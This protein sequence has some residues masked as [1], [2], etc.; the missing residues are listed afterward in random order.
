MAP[1]IAHL[2]ANAEKCEKAVDSAIERRSEA[3]LLLEIAEAAVVELQ[4][5]VDRATDEIIE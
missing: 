4:V 2:Q 1:V 5:R 3:H